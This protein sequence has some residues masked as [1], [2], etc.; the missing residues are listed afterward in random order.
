MYAHPSGCN[1]RLEHE[2]FFMVKRGNPD[3]L[4]GVPEMTILK[5][6]E[7]QSMYGYELFSRSDYGPIIASILARAVFILCFIGWRTK[8][9]YPAARETVSGRQRI[10]YR[11]TRAGKKRLRVAVKLGKM[12]FRVCRL[13]C[14][15]FNMELNQWL[16]AIAKRMQ[17]ASFSPNS[18]KRMTQSCQIII[19]ISSMLLTRRILVKLSHDLER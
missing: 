1:S 9:Y 17:A 10:I 16:S 5:L 11:T 3:F 8:V 13:C 7:S 6:L 19:R 4:N 14:K 15:E 18:I 2:G 12:L